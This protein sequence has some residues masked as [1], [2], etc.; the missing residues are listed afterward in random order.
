MCLGEADSALTGRCQDVFPHV[1]VLASGGYYDVVLWSAS[2][3]L[4]T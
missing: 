2:V 3:P 1:S 4:G